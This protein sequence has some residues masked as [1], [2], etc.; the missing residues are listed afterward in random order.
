[1]ES[2]ERIIKV[3][4]TGF[5]TLI[6]EV[7]NTNQRIDQTNSR[8]DQTNERLDQTNS[9]LS[10]HT[11]QLEQINVQLKGISV[12]LHAQEKANSIL[13]DRILKLEG[14]VPRVRKRRK[15]E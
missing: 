14:R 1:M 13:T 3:L 2:D 15:A 9:T 12:F 4:Q 6:D 5:Q 8:L 11:E 7:K 10:Q